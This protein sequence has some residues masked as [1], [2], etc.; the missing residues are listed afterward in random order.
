MIGY[1]GDRIFE[2][3]D[4]RILT[5]RD[6]K[7]DT[8]SRF[9]THELIN[10]KP[11]TEYIGPGLQIITFTIGLNASHGVRPKDEINAWNEMAEKG[12]A[13]LLVIGGEPLGADRWVVKS[14]SEAW[15][16]VFNQGELYSASL[17]ITLEEYI[18]E[19]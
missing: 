11:I 2:T 4:K 12:K 17:D 1:L 13:E 19:V 15:G 7:R 18:T 6:F 5:F 16:T 9:A 3:S 8:A 10:R 14:V